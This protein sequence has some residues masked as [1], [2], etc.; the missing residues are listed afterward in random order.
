MPA[1][2]AAPAI[3]FNLLGVVGR[4]SGPLAS[5]EDY[6]ESDRLPGLLTREG[7]FSWTGA[8]LGSI[9]V[10]DRRAP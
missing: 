3:L 7:R 6:F 2:S 4:E 1:L 5:V 8:I 9:V 10:E